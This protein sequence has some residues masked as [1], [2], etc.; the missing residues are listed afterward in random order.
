MEG[1]VQGKITKIYKCLNKTFLSINSIGRF[2]G[3]TL[4]ISPNLAI[5]KR[6]NDMFSKIESADELVNKYNQTEKR[7]QLERNENY[8]EDKHDKTLYGTIEKS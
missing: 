7:L 5:Q 3:N 2:I 6:I 4:I 8:K 1:D